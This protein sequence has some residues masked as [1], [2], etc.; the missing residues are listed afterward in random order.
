MTAQ[1]EWCGA[2]QLALVR[3]IEVARVRE[4]CV[5]REIEIRSVL[6]RVVVRVLVRVVGVLLIRIVVL[7]HEV[8][9]VGYDL[10]VVLVRVVRVVV[11]D[12]VCFRNEEVR[13]VRDVLYGASRA[14]WPPS[15]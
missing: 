5:P 15:L 1:L 14:C 8:G 3:V 12:F 13:G 7:Y 4:R 9:Q 2:V 6:I 10:R 11:R